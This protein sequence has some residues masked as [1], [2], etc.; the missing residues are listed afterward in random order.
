[1]EFAN[2]NG[3]ILKLGI[4]DSGKPAGIKK[5]VK[6]LMEGLPN[7][8]RSKL[9]ITPLVYLEKNKEREIISIKIQTAVFPVFFEGKI[10]LRS[11]STTQELNGAE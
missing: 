7:I 5:N 2:S 1:M 8:T 4:N 10:C 11:G 6:K 3:G 9:T